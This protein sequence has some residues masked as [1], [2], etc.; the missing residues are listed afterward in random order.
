VKRTSLVAAL[1]ASLVLAV[2]FAVPAA[3]E[4]NFHLDYSDPA[5]DV[6]QLWTSN[7]SAVTDANGD[8]IARP[9][10]DSINIVWTRSVNATDPANVTVSVDTQGRIA[11]RDDTSY[12]FQLF[13]N[14]T[15]TSYF[16]VTYANGTTTLDSTDPDF[17]PVDL[18][19]NSTITNVGP[20]SIQNRLRIN[21]E[22]SLLGTI[23]SWNVRLLALQVEPTYTYRDWGWELPGNPGSAPTVLQGFVTEAGAALAGVN[24]STDVGGYW[25][26]TNSSGGYS[27]SLSPG[28]YNVSFNLV[29]YVPQTI[30]VTIALGETRDLPIQLL[31]QGLTADAMT[32]LIVAVIAAAAI[33]GLVIFA[34]KRR[35]KGAPPPIT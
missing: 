5:S 25:T 28:T 35:R 3:A 2:A 23:T 10:P 30:Q 20:P 6:E 4:P 19:G 13:T 1:A 8:P 29:G 18:T 16:R 14:P 12:E 21:V 34:I 17:T 24:V 27:L 11:N 32:L 9:F 7:M 26:T 15:Y 22:K 31:R 33:G